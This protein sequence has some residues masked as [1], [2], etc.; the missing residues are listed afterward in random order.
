MALDT[1]LKRASAI[2]GSSPW[3]SILPF[4][5]AAIGQGDRQTVGLHYS[6]V[7]AG[8]AAAAVAKFFNPF[9]AS[10]GNLMRR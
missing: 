3:R 4:P 7:L 8:G 6:G 5:D 10:V 2:N 9:V 1:A